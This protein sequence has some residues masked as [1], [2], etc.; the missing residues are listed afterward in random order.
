ML[1]LAPMTTE[2]DLERELVA[3]TVA[4]NERYSRRALSLGS[5]AR[6]PEGLAC[7]ML[8][9]AHDS[10]V[11]RSGYTLLDAASCAVTW[12]IPLGSFPRL[13]DTRRLG[14][15]SDHYND[16]TRSSVSPS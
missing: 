16:Y 2:Y 6:D 3:Q 10:P 13:A 15:L 4:P 5:L 9:M 11:G 8:R 1:P 12:G 14:R 7:A